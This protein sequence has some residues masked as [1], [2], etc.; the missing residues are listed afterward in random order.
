MTGDPERMVGVHETEAARVRRLCH[1][2]DAVV[3]DA[4]GYGESTLASRQSPLR[5]AMGTSVA[6]M[7]TLE[8]E[9]E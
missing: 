8:R 2:N 7:A 9:Q 1:A 6:L 3:A 5:C 4:N